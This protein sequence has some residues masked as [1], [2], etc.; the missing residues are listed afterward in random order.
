MASAAEKTPLLLCML[1]AAAAS[2]IPAPP[3]WQSA[4]DST[5]DVVILGTGLK[6]SL[7]A[8][9]L[10]NNGKRV[11]QLERSGVRG[12][13][14]ASVNLQQLAERTSGPE[15]QLSP[16][17]VGKLSAYSIDAVPKTFMASGTQMQLFVQGGAWSHMQ[18][19][20]VQRSLLYRKKPDGTTDVHRVLANTEDVLKTR[21]LKTF[22]KTKMLQ[23]T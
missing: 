14:G 22:E 16:A 3:S 23:A 12:G 21:I 17:R 2:T 10:A 9:L 1:A 6:P 13:E 20:R 8:G 15:E 7:L 11:L 4:A 19:K 18:M 5:Y